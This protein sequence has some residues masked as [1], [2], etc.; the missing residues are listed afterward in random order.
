MPSR[1]LQ[2]SF[3]IHAQK[4]PTP[5]T[6]QQ[7]SELHDLTRWIC[8]WCSGRSGIGNNRARQT[9]TSRPSLMQ[10][11]GE[12]LFACTWFDERPSVRTSPNST[13][14]NLVM[15]SPGQTF[16]D[17]GKGWL[18]ESAKHFFRILPDPPVGWRDVSTNS[19]IRR[20]YCFKCRRIF[21]M[22]KPPRY[23]R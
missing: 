6:W 12:S 15:A 1:A 14:G 19:M 5:V 4:P 18:H 3:I 9:V 13:L 22:G 16:G 2:S 17:G 21:C 7:Q 20:H 10:A 23:H 8:D 11:E